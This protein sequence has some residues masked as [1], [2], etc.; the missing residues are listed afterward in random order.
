MLL[1]AFFFA[2]L[3]SFFAFID[4]D[5]AADTDCATDGGSWSGSDA[6]NGTC[7]YPANSAVAISN[8]GAN[9]DSVVIFSGGELVQD[10]C[11]PAAVS[12]GGGG[13]G[14]DGPKGGCR[15]GARP[16]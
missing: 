14:S 6:D 7:I 2:A 11:S 1:A 8:C 13:P 15:S 12:S 10:F 3:V 4:S 5:A 16:A 9:N